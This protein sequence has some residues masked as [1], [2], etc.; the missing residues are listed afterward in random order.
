MLRHERVNGELEWNSLSV[1]RHE[2]VNGELEWNSLSV[3]RLER[4]NGWPEWNSLSV[5]TNGFICLVKCNLKC[6]AHCINIR[7]QFTH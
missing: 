5:R 4:A 3:R 2:R 6:F 7:L 1:L